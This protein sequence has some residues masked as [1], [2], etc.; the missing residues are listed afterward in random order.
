MFVVLIQIICPQKNFICSYFNAIHLFIRILIIQ[1]DLN[2]ICYN[3]VLLL[4]ITKSNFIVLTNTCS[5]C[6]PYVKEFSA[7]NY[8]FKCVKLKLYSHTVANV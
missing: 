3:I 7:F 1:E 8:G 6:I 5:I 2:Q 4:L